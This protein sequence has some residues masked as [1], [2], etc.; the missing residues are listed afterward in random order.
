MVPLQSA[1]VPDDASLLQSSILSLVGDKKVPRKNNDSGTNY[2]RNYDQVNTR[3]STINN[4]LSQMYGRSHIDM[5]VV[6]QHEGLQGVAQSLELGEVEFCY[7]DKNSDNFYR[8][9]LSEDIPKSILR[10]DF[11]TI[12]K[13][14][15]LRNTPG[16][17]ELT[18]L[19]VV[20]RENKLYHDLLQFK[21]FYLYKKW[22]YFLLLRVYVKRK[23]FAFA[24]SSSYS[25]VSI[26]LRDLKLVLTCH[27]AIPLIC[28]LLFDVGDAIE[29]SSA[30][31]GWK[32]C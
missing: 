14:G 24:V 16:N 17:S 25:S 31:T 8:Y 29:Q 22:K 5:S 19:P 30:S 23:K 27:S 28:V 32:F 26:L 20:L 12:S 6:S 1:I 7:L 11:V 4:R 15:L 2:N 21:V 9:N 3:S 13:N 18:S 10:N